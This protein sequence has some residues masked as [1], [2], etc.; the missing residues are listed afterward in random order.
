[1][2]GPH[3]AAP[4]HIQQEV[5]AQV[6][7][8][9]QVPGIVGGAPTLIRARIFKLLRSPRIYSKEPKFRQAV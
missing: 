1:V 2:V 9:R 3:H 7:A 8:G 6:Q 4:R 5:Q